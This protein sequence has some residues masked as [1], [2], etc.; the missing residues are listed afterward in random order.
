MELWTREIQTNEQGKT[1][2]DQF[3]LDEDYNVPEAKRDVRRIVGSESK[4]V[5]ENVTW[6]EN[7]VK[8]T[9]KIEFHVLYVGEGLDPV[10]STLEGKITFFVSFFKVSILYQNI[11]KC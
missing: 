2:M 5:V 3:M 8:V 11:F 10:L 7:Y 1:L 9:G 4:P 6:V